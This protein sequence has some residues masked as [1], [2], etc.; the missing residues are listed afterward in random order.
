METEN[1]LAKRI[2][3]AGQNASYDNYCKRLLAN[4]QILAWILKTCVA[5]FRDCSIKNIAEKYIE[6]TP[7]VS[8][9]AVQQDD[10]QAVWNGI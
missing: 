3:A 2:D 4:K 10:F 7:Q 6:G 5:E 1:A 9:V 8:K